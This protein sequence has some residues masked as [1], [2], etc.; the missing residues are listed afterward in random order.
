[1]TERDLKILLGCVGFITGFTGGM[2]F[3]Y[4][5]WFSEWMV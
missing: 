2:I 3:G 1:M 4:F 5:D